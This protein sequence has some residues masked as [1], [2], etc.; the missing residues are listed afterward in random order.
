[1]WTFFGNYTYQVTTSGHFGEQMIYEDPS[2]QKKYDEATINLYQ[3]RPIPTP[4]ARFNLTLYTPDNYGPEFLDQYP[5]GGYMLNLLLDWQ[6]GPWTTWNPKNI[7]RIQY[8]VRETDY[9]NSILRLSKTFIIGKFQVMAF[10]DV[11]NLFNY[12]RMSLS[13]FTGKAGDRE[14]YFT[15]LHLPESE[16]YDNIPGNDRVGDY[17][18][19]G[20]P[21]Q[22]MFPRGKINFGTDTGDAGVI[23]YDVTARKY[24]E[25]SNNANLPNYQRWQQVDPAKINKINA[26][27]AYIDMPDYS[28]FS[29]FNPRQWFFGLRISLQID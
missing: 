7:T 3:D 20:V 18:K 15:S 19:P 24:Y 2:E 6:A 8:N 26:D 25:Y 17:R 16:A 22:P 11:D 5:L 13:N 12:R 4:Y 27:K 28:S 14:Y 1:L 21:Y 23:Y 10:M 29:F 9:F